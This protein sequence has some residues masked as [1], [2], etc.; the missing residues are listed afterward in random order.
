MKK[1]LFSVS[2]SIILF[3][4]A[5]LSFASANGYSDNTPIPN[6][7][8]CSDSDRGVYSAYNGTVDVSGKL[9]IMMQQYNQATNSWTTLS[10]KGVFNYPLTVKANGTIEDFEKPQ[11]SSK[12]RFE[13]HLKIKVIQISL[14]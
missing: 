10:D 11:K 4:F 9:N 6:S 5:F 3:A 12:N 7:V 8:Y 13:N 1:R 2:F 14:L